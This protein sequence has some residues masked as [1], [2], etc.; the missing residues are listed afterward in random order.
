MYNNNIE[1]I[2][3]MNFINKNRNILLNLN[4]GRFKIN[5]LSTI[6]YVVSPKNFG[7][8]YRN[9]F[10]LEK[11]KILELKN[12]HN[13]DSL[14]KF[15]DKLHK[16]TLN[17]EIME[18]SV[19]QLASNFFSSFNAD[20]IINKMIQGKK[21]PREGYINPDG[22]AFTAEQIK[23][24]WENISL[25]SRNRGSWMHYNI[26]RYFNNLSIANDLPELNQFT[27]FINSVVKQNN[28]IPYRT[29][30]KICG[31]DEKICGTIDFI[32]KLNDN[33]Y[34]LYDWK[35]L[36]NVNN[37]LSHIYGNRAM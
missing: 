34:V 28:I 36:Q 7:F 29:E 24:K 14:I 26:E 27:E 19:M 12:P 21:W 22:S 17:G 3:K 1:R 11:E 35:R 4:Y 10:L 18:L 9:K 37:S 32:G 2:E 23:K 16:Y 20:D 25:N 8:N 33:T 31:I 30:W 15:D 13:L 6:N 5:Q